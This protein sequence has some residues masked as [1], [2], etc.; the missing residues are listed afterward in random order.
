MVSCVLALGEQ[1]KSTDVRCG[2]V[3]VWG[4]GVGLH[5]CQDEW[6]A[7]VAAPSPSTNGCLD[8]L[9]D[10]AFRLLTFCGIAR[11]SALNQACD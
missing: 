6:M 7:I 4:V 10:S 5:R 8:A 9:N 2:I 3:V 1:G 11:V